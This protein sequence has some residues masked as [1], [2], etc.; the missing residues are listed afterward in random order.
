MKDDFKKLNLLYILSGN[1]SKSYFDVSIN[2]FTKARNLEINKVFIISV[3]EAATKSLENMENCFFDYSLYEFNGRL[4][5]L[6]KYLESLNLK[7]KLN[8]LTDEE[9]TIVTDNEL[10]NSE[11][12]FSSIFKFSS[13]YPLIVLDHGL[14]NSQDTKI[15]EYIFLSR[16]FRNIVLLIYY[17]LFNKSLKNFLL[18]K[19]KRLYLHVKSPFLRFNKFFKIGLIDLQREIDSYSLKEKIYT[20]NKEKKESILIL[21]SGAHR[22]KY[23]KFRENSFNSYKNIVL[24]PKYKNFQMILKIKPRE[25]L[26]FLKKNLLNINPNIKFYDSSQSVGTILKNHNI[27]IAF[28]SFQSITLASLTMIELKTYGYCIN[29]PECL[30]KSSFYL[31]LYRPNKLFKEIYLDKSKYIYID[32]IKLKNFIKKNVA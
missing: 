2:K 1:W 18:I 19:R 23:K 4:T 30:K 31:N 32:L 12:L 8:F 9:W 28:T 27:K 11:I 26:S 21:T 14:K 15:K 16:I 3:T 20:P 10:R 6:F 22:Y 24:N 29:V 17:L 13:S 5:L 25:D 7:K